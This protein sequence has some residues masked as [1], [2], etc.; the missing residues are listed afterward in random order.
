MVRYYEERANDKG[1][2]IGQVVMM[3]GGA[4]VPGLSDYLT[5]LLRL[6]VRT[7][8]PWSHLTFKHITEP[9]PADKSLYITAAGLALIEP[10][11]PFS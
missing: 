6:P 7:C 4:N 1:K 10:K 11:E 2:K 9:A 8:D 5:D 3:G